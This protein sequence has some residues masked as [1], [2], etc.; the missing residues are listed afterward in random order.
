L[1]DLGDKGLQPLVQKMTIVCGGGN[2]T[3]K[4]YGLT[5]KEIRVVEEN[6]G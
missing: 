6:V 3:A 4:L 2:V 5:D 1:E